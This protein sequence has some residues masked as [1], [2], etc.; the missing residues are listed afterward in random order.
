MPAHGADFKRP[1]VFSTS[2]QLRARLFVGW[3]RLGFSNNKLVYKGPLP[4]SCYCGRAHSPMIGTTDSADFLTATSCALGSK[5]WDLFIMDDTLEA[6]SDSLRDGGQTGL[7]PLAA[8]GIDPLLSVSLASC[9]GSRPVSEA[10]K[11]GNLTKS[12][13][14]DVPGIYNIHSYFSAPLPSSSWS[15]LRSSFFSLWKVTLV[16]GLIDPLRSTTGSSSPPILS[17]PSFLP[18]GTSS[19]SPVVTGAPYGSL[20]ARFVGFSVSLLFNNNFP[21]VF[22]KRPVGSNGSV[23]T[24]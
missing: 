15:S 24:V 5:F 23:G 9:I 10:W 22:H 11:A 3:P 17:S 16:S 6:R 8:V 7:A 1:L 19:F 21:L 13:L 20:N 2:H 18:T 4:V 14:S 12:M